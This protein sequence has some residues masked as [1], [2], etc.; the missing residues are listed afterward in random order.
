MLPNFTGEGCYS[1]LRPVSLI[2]NR[3]PADGGARALQEKEAL[4]QEAMDKFIPPWPTMDVPSPTPT[5]A[6]H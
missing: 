3:Q 5:T 1:H 4:V 6:P 2:L